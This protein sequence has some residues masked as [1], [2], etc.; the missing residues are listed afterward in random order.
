MDALT[1]AG[2]GAVGGA[3]IEILYVWSSLTAWQQARRK[4]RSKRKGGKLPRLDEYLDPVADSLV[5]ATRL[6]L[7][8]AACLLF[9]DQITGTMAAIAVGASAPALLRQVGTLRSL[10]QIPD[11]PA[12]QA[13]EVAP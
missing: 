9:K 1:A 13:R 3:V 2:L 11:A 10:R 7:G 6:A 12:E 8:A 4:A 5:A